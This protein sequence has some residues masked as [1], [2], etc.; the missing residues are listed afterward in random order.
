MKADTPSLNIVINEIM[1]DPIGSEIDEE[2][3]ELYNNGSISVNLDNW[4]FTDSDGP[5]DFLFSNI[6]FPPKTYIVLHTAVGVNES[7]FSD[8]VAHFFMSKGSAMWS[9]SGD[10]A[11]LL[12]ESGVGIDYVAY[13]DIASTDP[14]PLE[15]EYTGSYPSAIE[16]NSISLHPNGRDKDSAL[17][18]EESDPTPG[19]QNAHLDDYPPEITNIL[20]NPQNPTSSESVSISASVIDDYKLEMV[21]VIYSVDAGSPLS[22]P[23]TYDGQNYITNIPAQ[24]DGSQIS[25]YLNATDDANQ[26]STSQSIVYAHSDSPKE[27]VINEFLANAESDWNNDSFYDNG[28][29][30]IELYNN[31]DTVVNIGGWILDDKLGSTGSS[32][33]YTIPMGVF[34]LPKE[35]IVFFGNETGVILNDFGDENVTLLDDKDN[36]IDII[37][38][39]ET[40]DDTAMGR[41][42]DGSSWKNFLSPTPGWENEYPVDSLVN[43]A[44]VK[45]N[46]F[47]PAPKDAYS[48]EWIE[49]YN[50]GTQPVSLDGCYLDDTLNGGTN[51]HQIPLNTTLLPGEIVVFER[52]FGLN[53]AGDSVNLVYVDRSTVIDSYSYTHSEYD[54]SHARGKDGQ[55]YWMTLSNPTP[56]ET[57]PLYTVYNPV[58]RPIKICKLFYRSSEETEFIGLFN[59][60]DS[61]IDIGGWRISDGVNSYSGTI[62]FPHGIEIPSKEHLYVANKAT[63]FNDIMGFLPDF[64]YGNSS[65]LVMEME[66]GEPPSFA[67]NSDEVR[68]MTEIGILTD[69]VVY[70]DSDYDGPGWIG[71]AVSDAKKGEYLIRNFDDVL[72]TYDDTHTASDWKHLRQYKVGQSEFDLKTSSYSGSLTV[73]ASPDTSYDTVIGEIGKAQSTIFISLYEFTN[74]NITEK[75]IEKLTQGVEVL[76]LMEGSPVGGISE[77]QKYVL[78]KIH[79]NG[80]NIRYLITNETLGPRYRFLHAKY[81]VI[82]NSSLIISSENWKYSGIPVLNTYGN[83]GWGAVIFDSS[84]AL[85]FTEVFFDDWHSVEYDIKPF[86]E[87]DPTYG[88]ASPDYILDDLVGTG[89]YY[90]N[91]SSNTVE[92]NFTVSAVL[93]PD[94]ALL[95]SDGILGMINSAS[96]SIYIEQLEMDLT[97]DRDDYEYENTYLK[98]IITA[99]EQRHVEVKI[100]LSS[101][102]SYPD[103]PKLDNYDTVS[104]INNYA[105][106]HNITKYLKARLMDY[107]RLGLS[108]LHNKGM[109][110]DGTKTLISSINWVRNSVTQNREVGVIIENDDVAQ[111]FTQIFF[112][113]WN[114]PPISNAGNDLTLNTSDTAH[115]NEPS[116]DSDDNIISYFWD[117]DDGTNSTLKNPSHRFTREGL[118]EVKLIVSDGQY[119]DS[120]TITVIVTE[121]EATEGELGLVIYAALLTIFIVIF[122]TIITF[123]RRMKFKFL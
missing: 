60:S 111:Y 39:S 58:G 6:M 103:N 59:P 86:T 16:G 98:A 76:I 20:H 24:A 25:Y 91:F 53:N 3:V 73:F 80:G 84:T 31:G 9:P 82:D 23:M 92:G 22:I 18:W 115:F 65:D 63:I 17:D 113:D 88:N 14:P 75:I 55:D 1:Y 44:F 19:Y 112:W 122:L 110:V 67:M 10:D 117:F 51:P 108:K 38:F 43:L 21:S 13:G 106:N 49:L 114:E 94:T 30:W 15:L 120:S 119:T 42:P 100:L 36:I 50:S 81:A 109:I 41:Y 116:Y 68:L 33:P 48:K 87:D 121:A 40:S 62:V 46:E 74:W 37:E 54:I 2:Y 83:R 97:W 64:E 32:D 69:I 7:D 99:A 79:E 118:Y 123:L 70:G 61:A 47:L 101:L 8:G 95:E 12:N 26:I 45:I 29:E 28:D 5:V 35:F 102:F 52:S 11:L 56:W 57:N 90:P 66:G 105:V 93:A 71:P 27:I 72:N 104:Y 4:T 34:L 89:D 96:E 85:Y 77:D 107:D 78:Q